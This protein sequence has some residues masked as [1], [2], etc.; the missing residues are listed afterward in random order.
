M[1]VL[2]RLYEITELPTLPEM[3]LRV[4]RLVNS[5]E[6]NAA[7][8]AKIIQQD[9]A[10]AAKVLKV[11]N[12]AFFSPANQRISSL[13]LAI[14]RIG[15][16]E[17]RSII[18]A[19]TLIKKFSKKSN[20]LDYKQFWR[21]SLASAYFSQTIINALPAK[22]SSEECQ[23]CFLSGLLHD[24]GI[25]VY[26][27]F[28]H[29]EFEQI[30]NSALSQEKSFLF[31]E[32][33]VAGKES[34]PV[35]GSALLE[36]WKIETPIISG[37]RFHHSFD[38]APDNQSRLWA[39]TYLTEYVLC[40]WALGSFEGSI[41]EENKFVWDILGLSPG[42]LSILFTKAQADVEKAGAILEMDIGDPNTQLRMI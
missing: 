17:I 7:I 18:M 34:H 25:L 5:E 15:F 42:S 22:Y 27:Q 30:M 6:G 41:Q 2:Q 1:N 36:L 23:I 10:L 9:P 13:Q 28:F 19:L 4:Q 26:D 35:V 14:A 11:A 31:A 39:V 16:N 21:H 24:I 3:M 38:K 37:V 12:S 8:L 40:N 33:L 20:I 32:Q 29:K